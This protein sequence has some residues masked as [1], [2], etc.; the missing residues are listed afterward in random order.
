MSKTFKNAVIAI[1]VAGTVFVGLLSLKLLVPGFDPGATGYVLPMVLGTGLFRGLNGRAGNRNTPVADAAVRAQALAF[2]PEPGRG[3]IVFI[4][5]GRSGRS[6]GFNVNVDAK[7]VVQLMTPRFAVVRATAGRHRLFADI[8]NAPGAST[9]Q[10]ID[11]ELGDGAVVFFRIRMVTG[12]M[13]T[14][15]RLDPEADTPALRAELGSIPM[16]M[17]DQ[18]DPKAGA[19][20]AF[21]TSKTVSVRRSIG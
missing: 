8:P 19:G 11:I 2:A 17:P 10:P 13:R 15:L 5:T 1:G 14:S 9:V 16:A 12:L 6:V 21:T 20:T 3:S 4:R 18:R 7:T